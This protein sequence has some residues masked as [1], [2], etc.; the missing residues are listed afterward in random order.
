MIGPLRQSGGDLAFVT[1][2]VVNRYKA[3]LAVIDAQ[4]GNMRRDAELAQSSTKCA[5]QVVMR[6]IRYTAPLIQSYLR[7]TPI[8]ETTIAI[9]KKVIRPVALLYAGD[10]VPEH[11]RQRQGT[12]LSVFGATRRNRPRSAQAHSM[13]C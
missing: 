10:D 12:G 9:A 4:L 6:P 13:M 7:V 8:P 1:V 2:L 11:V 5:A 3:A